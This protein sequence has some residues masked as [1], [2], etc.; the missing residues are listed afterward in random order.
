MGTKA[1]SLKSRLDRNQSDQERL[2][3]RVESTRQRLLRQYQG[4]DSRIAQLNGLAA[5]VT[6]QFGNR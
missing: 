4:V 6:Q 3:A 2:N 1:Q 5:Y